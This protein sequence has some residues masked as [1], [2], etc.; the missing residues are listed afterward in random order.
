[1]NEIYEAFDGKLFET[2][3]SCLD[4]ENELKQ[5]TYNKLPYTIDKIKEFIEPLRVYCQDMPE[6]VCDENCPLNGICHVAV[7]NWE[8]D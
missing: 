3:E 2:R 6:G 4:Y 8:L 7:Y 1:M 5:R